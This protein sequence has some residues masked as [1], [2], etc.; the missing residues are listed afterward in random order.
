[1]LIHDL[2]GALQ[3]KIKKSGKKSLSAPEPQSWA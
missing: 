3:N 1:M 2:V